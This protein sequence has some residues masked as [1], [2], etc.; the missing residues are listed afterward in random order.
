MRSTPAPSRAMNT[1]G[2]TVGRSDGPSKCLT[3]RKSPDP[4]S[5][6]VAANKTGRRVATRARTNASPSVTSAVRPRALSE[7]PG[8]SS[9]ASR[10]ATDTSNS[11][12][13]TVS[14]CAL[15]TTH[16]FPGSLFPYHAWVFP[17]ASM[18]TSSRPAS[19]NSAA[20]RAPRAASEPVG[21]GIADSSAWRSSVPASERSMWARAARTPSWVSKAAITHASY[22]SWGGF[23]NSKPHSLDLSRGRR[24]TKRMEQRELIYDWNRAGGNGA[25]DWTRAH[26]DLND[27]TLRDGLQSPSV[28]DPSLAVKKRLLH[29]MADLGIVAADIGLPGAGPRVVD[30]VRAL[31]TEIR[32]HR[33]PVVP[34]CA[35]R[36][37]VADIEPIVRVAEE[38][39]IKIEAATFIGSSPIRQYAEDWTID[40]ILKASEEAVTYAVKHGLPVMYVTEDTTRAR[41]DTLK[42]LYGAAISCGAGR[43]CLADT[44]GHA[45]PAGVQALVKYVK[46]EIVKQNDVKIDWH[47]HRD[48]G[49]GLI[50]CLAAIE[51][52]VDRVHAT[53]LGVGERVGNAEMDLLI[54]N[55]KLLGAHRH[56]IRKLPEYCRIVAESVGIPIPL[57]YPVMGS[58]AFRTGTGVHAAAIIKAKKKGHS[59]LADRVYSSVPA[60]ELGLEQVIEISPVSGLS[61]VKYWLSSHGYDPDDEAACKALFDAAKQADRTLTAE[62]CHRLL[63]QA[64]WR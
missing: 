9:R 26:V 20:T 22:D 10:R 48:R 13:N 23:G 21:A 52:G 33:L 27:E 1:D 35:A 24:D 28:T 32:D 36:T 53:A 16:P 38:V 4:S 5:P 64:A 61:N 55:L 40:R 25:F 14:R 59:W 17:T 19:A 18:A 41:P 45:T 47:G 43:I 7:M 57:N 49:M 15:T 50:N 54:V 60:E 51:A 56:D 62:E 39:G 44:V 63:R 29:L 42:A 3:P 34:N 58:D 46:E 8:P 12:P 6:T 11:G 31:A 37:V 2:R 30:Q